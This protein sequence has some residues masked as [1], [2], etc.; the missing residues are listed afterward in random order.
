MTPT[1]LNMMSATPAPELS[2][3]ETEPAP[4]ETEHTSN[5]RP[6]KIEQDASVTVTKDV[7]DGVTESEEDCDTVVVSEPMH[8]S[9]DTAR[10]YGPTIL[11]DEIYSKY[12]KR[13]G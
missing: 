12:D 9:N 3:T 13:T 1:F 8:N 4:T 11:E 2:P 5:D 10:A 7:T 6:M